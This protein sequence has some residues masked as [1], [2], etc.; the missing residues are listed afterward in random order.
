MWHSATCDIDATKVVLTD[1]LGGGG[2]ATCV[3]EI[4]DRRGANGIYD[5]VG[6][7]EDRV[8]HN[9]PLV[10]V[11]GR[12]IMVQSW[13]QGGVSVYDDELI[14]AGTWS[15][16]WYNG[17]VYSF[18]VVRGSDVLEV[19]GPEVAKAQGVKFD[20]LNVQTQPVYSGPGN[21]GKGKG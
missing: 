18:D 1:E 10:P 2:A 14:L 8:A 7:G 15:T 11:A 6:S 12:D 16:Y 21:S 19:A 9:G 13:Y 17:L 5:V 3:R 20:E 4:D